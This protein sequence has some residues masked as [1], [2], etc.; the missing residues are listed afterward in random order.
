M[1]LANGSL[2][3]QTNEHVPHTMQSLAQSFSAF[4]KSPF[5]TAL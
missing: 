4:A 3:G 5:I 1:V 2:D